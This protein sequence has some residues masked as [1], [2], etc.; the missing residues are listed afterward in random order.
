MTIFFKAAQ[1]WKLNSLKIIFCHNSLFA[2]S[3]PTHMYT[4]THTHTDTLKSL[5]NPESEIWFQDYFEDA[6]KFFGSLK[7]L[8]QWGPSG[9]P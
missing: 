4:Q 5:E 2:L 7:S 8:P 3:S 1:E 6:V 9:E